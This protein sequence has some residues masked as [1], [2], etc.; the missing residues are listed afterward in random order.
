[1]HGDLQEVHQ[2]TSKVVKKLLNKD[3]PVQEWPRMKYMLAGSY[4]SMSIPSVCKRVINMHQ[5]LTEF[6]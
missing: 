5:D 6:A 1:M 2:E 4:T 3:K